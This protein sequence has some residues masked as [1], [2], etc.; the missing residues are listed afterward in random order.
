MRNLTSLVSAALFL[1]LGAN[2]LHAASLEAYGRLPGMDNVTLSP[3]GAQIAFVQTVGDKHLLRVVSV[4]DGKLADSLDLDGQRMRRLEWADNKKLLITTSYSGAPPMVVT[5]LIGEVRQLMLLNTTTHK[6]IVLPNWKQAAYVWGSVEIGGYQVRR[7]N[8]RTV[9]FLGLRRGI[10]RIDLDSGVRQLVWR[11]Y[12][13]LGYSWV[14]GTNGYVAA[15]ETDDPA[16]QRWTL[17]GRV[18]GAL[19]PI[20]SGTG[21]IDTKFAGYGPKADSELVEQL[22]DGK[23]TWRLLS[24]KYGT[25]DAPLPESVDFAAPL[26]DLY[27]ERLIGFVRAGEYNQYV[28]FDAD[29]QRRW[30]EVQATFPGQQLTLVSQDSNFRELV[31]LAATPAQGLMYQLV[32]TQTHEVQPLGAAYPGTGMP[33]E[34]RRVDYKGGDGLELSADLTLPRDRTA[35]NLP[36]VVLSEGGPS[37]ADNGTFDDKGVFDWWSQALAQQGYAVLRPTYPTRC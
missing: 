13:D 3:D 32:D 33:L 1:V 11:T 2:P 8:G 15:Y 20:A 10:L 31:V 18:N 7:L 30:Q 26:Q 16:Q 34:V 36:L 4:R 37:R 9:L 27:Q 14:V 22:Q 19:Q 29:M 5:Q 28:F 12:Y 25:L 17:R 21:F 23:P 24:L 35:K 6:Y